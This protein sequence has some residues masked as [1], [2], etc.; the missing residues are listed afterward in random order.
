MAKVLRI[1]VLGCGRIGVMHAEMLAGRVPGAELAGVYDVVGR[2]AAEVADRLGVGA[3]ASAEELLDSGIDAVAICTSTDTHPELIVAAAGAGLAVFCEKPISLDL[4]DIDSAVAAVDKA[5]VLL[6]VGF[7]RRFDPSHAAVREA[8]AVGALGELH[9]VRITSRDPAP[10]PRDYLARSGGLFYD[11]TIHDFDMA[12]FITGS[13]VVEVHATAALR[14]E[15]SLA[16]VA[17]FDTAVVVLR[18]QSGCITTIDNSWQAVYG[19][20]QRVEAF[21]SGGVAASENQPEHAAWR[22]DA[23]GLAAAPI[24]HFFLERYEEA[25]LRQWDAFVGAVSTGGAALVTG[26]DGRAPVVIAQAATESARTG[27]P[28]SIG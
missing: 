16:D 18:H 1:G 21:G 3:A 2:A 27:H 25:Y 24:R 19:Y 28:V 12:R 5:G 23:T 8:V 13:E 4:D 9:L 11:T 7:N 26:A 22:R 15:P 17:E 6:Q 20:D 14:I 10:P